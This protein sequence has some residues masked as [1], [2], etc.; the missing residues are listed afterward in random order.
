VCLRA[1]ELEREDQRRLL[2]EE[3]ERVGQHTDNLA[4]L[5]VQHDAAPDRGRIGAEAGAPVAGHQDHGIG[6]ARRIVLLREQAPERRRRA[7]HRQHAVG[8]IDGA[9]LLGLRDPGD[10]DGV[11]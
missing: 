6:G 1:I 2:I 7:E 8:D 3:P 11:G 4:R 5:A 10:A 9:D